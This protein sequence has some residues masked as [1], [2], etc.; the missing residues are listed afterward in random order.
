MR[1]QNNISKELRLML[2]DDLQRYKAE[3]EM[4]DE[5]YTELCQW[6]QSG[7]SPYD[8]GWSIATDAG[9]PM[10]YISAKRIVES[11][12]ELVAA[13]DTVNDDPIFLIPVNED[14][15]GDGDIPF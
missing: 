13:Y 14:D 15:A 7:H 9:T 5:E 10:D 4:N 6:V 11:G 12:V 3:I 1:F 2:T 8:N